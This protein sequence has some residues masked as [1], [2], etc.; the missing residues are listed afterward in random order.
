MVAAYCS[1]DLVLSTRQL[2][3]AGAAEST[4]LGPRWGKT[5]P[6]I[7]STGGWAIPGHLGVWLL[8]CHDIRQV[9]MLWLLWAS[10]AALSFPATCNPLR[11]LLSTWAGDTWGLNWLGLPLDGTTEFEWSGSPTA[12]AHWKKLKGT[13]RRDLEQQKHDSLRRKHKWTNCRAMILFHFEIAW[14]E[15]SGIVYIKLSLHRLVVLQSPKVPLASF[16]YSAMA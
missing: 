10:P 7:E 14:S 13:E 12:M 4:S 8:E 2:N 5:G 15:S 11:P 6:T 16:D 1:L 3:P 9:A